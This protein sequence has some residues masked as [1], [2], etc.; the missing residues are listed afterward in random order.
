MNSQI[1]QSQT[2]RLDRTNP[3]DAREKLGS[4]FTIRKE[5]GRSLQINTLDVSKIL[6]LS[7]FEDGESYIGSRQRQTRFIEA[8]FI[9]LDALVHQ[10]ILKNQQ[11]AFCF[12]AQLSDPNVILAF[13]GTT[14]EAYG[15]FCHLCLSR[16]QDRRLTSKIWYDH[17][18][19][20]RNVL[21]AVIHKDDLL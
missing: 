8:G 16:D 9:L 5:D 19:V 11:F 2:L 21:S 18:N 6:A 17:G 3:F 20:Y 15:N 7:M 1:T 14:F 13:E 4:R 12:E 10:E